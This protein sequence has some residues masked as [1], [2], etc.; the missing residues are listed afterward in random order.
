MLQVVFYSV[1]LFNQSLI[2]AIAEGLHAA[3]HRG[4]VRPAEGGEAATPEGGQPW[5]TGEERSHAA[6]RRHPL[7][8]RQRGAAAP[9]P[10]GFT[11]LDC[12]G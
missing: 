2:P 7:Q 5:R 12:Q 3:A 8:P 11:T 6:T 4:Q 10:E 1:N 9:V